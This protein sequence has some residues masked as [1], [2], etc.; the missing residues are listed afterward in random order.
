MREGIIRE[1]EDG[2]TVQNA[3]SGEVWVTED[4]MV[5]DA[6]GESAGFDLTLSLRIKLI[7]LLTKVLPVDA[8]GELCRKVLDVTKGELESLD[9][10]V[11]NELPVIQ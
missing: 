7:W 4:R 10:A 11:G 6:C 1:T 9:E 8:K 3:D 2:G 5:T